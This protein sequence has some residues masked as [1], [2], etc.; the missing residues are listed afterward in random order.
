MSNNSFLTTFRDLILWGYQK[1]VPPGKNL[2]A[3]NHRLYKSQLL[4]LYNNETYHSL[5]HCFCLF[6]FFL[7]KQTPDIEASSFLYILRIPYST[8]NLS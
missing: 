5:K 6:F 2:E 4:Q 7:N 3:T 1:K 8:E